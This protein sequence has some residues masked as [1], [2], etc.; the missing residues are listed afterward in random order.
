[1]KISRRQ[2]VNLNPPLLISSLS[3]V[4]KIKFYLPRFIGLL[5]VRQKRKYQDKI[6][7]KII[8]IMSGD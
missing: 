1:M 7:I 4:A 3:D 6:Q 8:S 2:K 5:I